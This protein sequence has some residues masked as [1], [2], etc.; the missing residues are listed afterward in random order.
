LTNLTSVQNGGTAFT[1]SSSYF[2]SETA[3][4]AGGSGSGFVASTNTTDE[5]SSLAAAIAT[6]GG[7]VGVT[8]TSSGAGVTVTATTAGT[9]GNSIGLTE[10]LSNFSWSPASALSG[11]ADGTNSSTTFAYWSVNNY[12][13]PSQVATNIASA[14]N[15]NST[16]SPVLSA[17]AN[18]PA[19]GNILIYADTVG[20]GGNSYA[21]TP[22]SFSA[23]TGGSLTGG[24]AGA[25]QPN[26]YPAKFSFS[27]STANCANDFVVYPTGVNGAANAANIIAYNNLYTT[28]CSGTVP[29]V[30]WAY[31]TG[32]TFTTSPILSYFDNTGS[33]V[34][35][36][37]VSGTTASLVLL[38]WKANAADSLTAPESLT[39]QSS[40]S[41][42]RNC[43]APCMYSMPF[44]NGKNDSLS[45]PFLDYASD[46]IYV[47]DDSGNLH[48][49]TGAF[50]G[51][52]AEAGSPWPVSVGSSQLASP[53]YDPTYSG[54]Q[55]FVGDLASA[56]TLHGVLASGTVTADPHPYATGIGAIADAPLVDGSANY[57]LVFTNSSAAN[58]VYGYSDQYFP[59]APGTIGLGA[60]AAGY[61]FYAGAYDNVY[62]QS[63]NHTGH[64]YVVGNTGATTGATLYQVSLSGGFL[65]GPLPWLPA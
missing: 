52:P 28:G 56:G 53:V 5:A 16:T 33:Q 23:F 59:N 51:N 14:I 35:F 11:G 34:A 38:K 26:A 7:A 39:R 12:A 19:A 57:L 8:A 17:T 47:G 10:S 42:Y 22:T 54:G 65:L 46:T 63:S 24:Q 48:K 31:N 2:G 20:V 25:V 43:T 41:A 36:I 64:V 44:A 6:G 45:S 13:T 58:T 27:T 50:L 3:L 37:Q 32:G 29:A 60:G 49:F 15:S 62:L 9:G 40:G 61:Y 55:I 18:S 4:W 1:S 21:A 30:Y